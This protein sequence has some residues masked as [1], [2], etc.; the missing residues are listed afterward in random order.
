MMMN[1][2]QT[3]F[4]T[5]LMLESNIMQWAISYYN[6]VACWLILKAYNELVTRTAIN[7]SVNAECNSMLRKVA[8][9]KPYMLENG[10]DNVCQVIQDLK[11]DTQ[12]III[13]ALKD[14]KGVMI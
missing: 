2:D 7:N 4:E 13:K 5:S 10:Y 3:R 14:D 6:I 12:N 9:F 11:T 8:K 1:S